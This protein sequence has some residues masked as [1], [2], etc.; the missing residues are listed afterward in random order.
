[1][2]TPSPPAGR[3]CPG[4]PGF[5]S[6]RGVPFRSRGQ[7]Q[8]SRRHAGAQ[9][10]L[11]DTPADWPTLATVLQ[12]GAASW[13]RTRKAG[14]S[15]AASPGTQAT[16]PRPSDWAAAHT[17]GG[18]RLLQPGA[19]LKGPRGGAGGQVRVWFPQDRV[20]VSGRG[21]GPRC[22]QGCDFLPS[23]RI[24]G[25]LPGR[26]VRGAPRKRVNS[27]A[28]SFPPRVRPPP[29]HL[30]LGGARFPVW[31]RLFSGTPRWGGRG[32]RSGLSALGPRQRSGTPPNPHRH[33]AEG[34]VGS[35]G[36]GK[37]DV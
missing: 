37:Q 10:R 4:V 30:R 5:A 11:G 34:A 24:L 25:S 15:L 29:R 23:V 9:P 14:Q 12:K 17:D 27:Q 36:P 6:P 1:M 3:G 2:E 18:A 31:H 22:E 16:H 8:C 35:W 7:T 28:P 19:H 26:Q 20:R 13:T 33:P 21:C 32:P